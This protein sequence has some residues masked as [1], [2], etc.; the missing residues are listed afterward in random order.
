[1][2]ACACVGELKLLIFNPLGETFGM[3][4]VQLQQHCGFL[5]QM[6]SPSPYG[7]RI[8]TYHQQDITI[9][10]YKV[11]STVQRLDKSRNSL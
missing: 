11:H 6:E 9:H 1:M 4:Q 2:R 10:G 3:Q 5:K 8:H 7:S